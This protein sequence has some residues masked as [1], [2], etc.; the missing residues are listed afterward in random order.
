MWSGNQFNKFRTNFKKNLDPICSKLK[1]LWTELQ[2][3]IRCKHFVE[4]TFGFFGIPLTSIFLST[5][6]HRVENSCYL[7][8]C[9]CFMNSKV[10]TKM[11]KCVSLC[12]PS[13]LFPCIQQPTDYHMISFLSNGI[14]RAKV[15]IS[16]YFVVVV[17]LVRVYAARYKK[18]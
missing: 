17:N 7:I 16:F 13:P 14:N 9:V 5:F 2:Y 12:V 4:F 3:R 8:A 18:R 11:H 6:L 1:F 10:N 15:N